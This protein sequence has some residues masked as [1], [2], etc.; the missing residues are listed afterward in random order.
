VKAW[1]YQYSKQVA[2]VGSDA[3]AHYV[4]WIDP[5]GRRKCKSCGPGKA[6]LKAA[7]KLAEKR[8]AELLTGVYEDKS[9]KRWDEFIVEYTAKVLSAA[10][11]TSR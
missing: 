3:A 5:D 7:Q 6:G 4:G 2:N 9:R 10:K 1:V 11:P 8:S